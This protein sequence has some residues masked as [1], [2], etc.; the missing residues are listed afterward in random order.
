M[1]PYKL[2]YLLFSNVSILG[3]GMLA[4]PHAAGFF[5][6]LIVIVLEMLRYGLGICH[7]VVL[8]NS[9]LTV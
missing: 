9:E 8:C 7:E 6:V 3:T 2:H 1:A 4:V 5:L